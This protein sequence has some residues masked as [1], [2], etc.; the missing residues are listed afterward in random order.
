MLQSD[1]LR[2]IPDFFH[3]FELGGL[4]LANR[5]LSQL[6]SKCVKVV[7]VKRISVEWRLINK[8]RICRQDGESSE[9]EIEELS[10][11]GKGALEEAVASAL[12]SCFVDMLYIDSLC[13]IFSKLRAPVAV[14]RLV[15]YLRGDEQTGELIEFLSSIRSIKVRF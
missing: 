13:G 3:S 5:R 15:M 10:V 7:H 4:L 9:M 1:A 12:S 14:N 2:E 11:S 8:A 6:A